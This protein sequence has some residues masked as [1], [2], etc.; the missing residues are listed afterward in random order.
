MLSSFSYGTPMNVNGWRLNLKKGNTQLLTWSA[1]MESVHTLS[2]Q[3][4]R[5]ICSR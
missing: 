3:S 2:V 4:F 1:G 5:E